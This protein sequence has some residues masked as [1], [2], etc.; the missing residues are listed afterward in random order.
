ML[1]VNAGV[2][3]AEA[4]TSGRRFTWKR[5]RDLETQQGRETNSPFPRFVLGPSDGLFLV[6]AARPPEQTPHASILAP[7]ARC[8]E[9]RSVMQCCTGSRLPRQSFNYAIAAQAPSCPPKAFI[10]SERICQVGTL[11][12]AT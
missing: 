4:G 9:R 1:T 12:V 5:P 10:G 6:K 7:L 2:F 8:P 3:G 11:G